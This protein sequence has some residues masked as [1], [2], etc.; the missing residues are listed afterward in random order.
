MKSKHVNCYWGKQGVG[1][2]KSKARVHKLSIIT[3]K[4]IGYR[5]IAT[6]VTCIIM[7]NV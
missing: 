6:C 2:T 7:Y 4:A 3:L 5:L 1:Q